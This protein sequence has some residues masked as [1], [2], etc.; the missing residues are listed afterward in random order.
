[1]KKLKHLILFECKFPLGLLSPF[2]LLRR[3]FWKIFKQNSSFLTGK[4]LDFGAGN[5]PYK[6]LFTNTSS[7]VSLDIETSGYPTEKKT[8][9]V[10]YDGKT[11]PF[12]DNTFDSIFASEVFEHIPNLPEILQELH[13]VLKPGGT[14]MVSFPFVWPE[15]EQP[16]DFRRLTRFGTQDLFEKDQQF[17]IMHYFTLCNYIETVFLLIIYYIFCL[18][19]KYFKNKKNPIFILLRVIIILFFVIPLNILAMILGFLLPNNIDLFTG[20]IVIAKKL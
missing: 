2:F 1:M 19:D 20:Q 18:P 11:I 10:Y 13:R 6:D 4:S 7:C 12:E 14:L 9:D 3:N 15:H 8:A 5:Q 16:Y 17:K